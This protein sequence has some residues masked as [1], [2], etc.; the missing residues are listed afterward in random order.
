MKRKQTGKAVEWQNLK[1]RN[2][3]KE[4]KTNGSPYWN[5]VEKHSNYEPLEEET[6]FSRANP[7][8]LEGIEPVYCDPVHSEGLLLDAIYT[9]LTPKQAQIM[10]LVLEGYSQVEI[11]RNLEVK[12]GYVSRVIK[13]SKEK[14][15]KYF[16]RNGIK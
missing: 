7:D 1:E 9:T 11:A 13:V 3:T 5:W 12:Q 4:E 6:E 8:V 14:L 10:S 15:K 2:I 16:E